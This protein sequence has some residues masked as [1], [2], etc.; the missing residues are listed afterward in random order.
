MDDIK[1]KSRQHFNST[2]ANYN[3][4]SDGKFCADM[5]LPLI[6]EIH[7]VKGGKLLDLG[8]GNGN[9]LVQLIKDDYTLTGVD[10]SEEMIE[11][12]KKR[13]DGHAEL[14]VADAEELPFPKDTFDILICNASFHHYPNPAG[15]LKEMRRVVRCGSTLLIGETY[16]PQPFRVMMNLCFRFSSEGDYHTYGKKELSALIE[17]H[18]FVVEKIQKTGKHTVL[19]TAKAKP[20]EIK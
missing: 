14:L 15:V 16:L 18:G 6:K 2:A 9:V 20:F 12:A 3:N 4:S 13:L 17:K 7:K 19:F 11:Q 8:C 10:L 5:Y 1:E